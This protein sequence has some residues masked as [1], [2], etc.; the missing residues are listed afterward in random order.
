[1][2]TIPI[3]YAQIKKGERKRFCLKA[4]ATRQAF[5]A[6]FLPLATCCGKL[7]C[8]LGSELPHRLLNIET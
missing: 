2:T 6:D 7:R 5:V 8:K 4:D 3:L 1:M